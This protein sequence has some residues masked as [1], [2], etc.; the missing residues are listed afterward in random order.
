[1]A[2]NDDVD[3]ELLTLMLMLSDFVFITVSV[4]ESATWIFVDGSVHG[5]VPVFSRIECHSWRCQWWR[6]WWWQTKHP[7]A[8]QID[9]GWGSDD[10]RRDSAH[11]SARTYLASQ[12]TSQLQQ[13]QDSRV[14]GCWGR[15]SVIDETTGRTDRRQSGTCSPTNTPLTAIRRR[16]VS[17]VHARY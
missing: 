9:S 13:Q 17:T 10:R 14:P 7:A 1:M 3:D 2:D 6:W 5:F 8:S 16:P 15:S 12:P 11:V 4:F